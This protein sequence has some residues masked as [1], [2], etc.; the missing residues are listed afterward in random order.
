MVQRV[1]GVVAFQRG[2]LAYELA[3]PQPPGW[4]PRRR[5]RGR[6]GLR[7]LL[8]PLSILLPLDLLLIALFATVAIVVAAVSVVLL[9]GY[10]VYR[11]V[12]RRAIAERREREQAAREA[13]DRRYRH[14]LSYWNQLEICHRCVGVFLPGHAWQH[15]EVTPAGGVAPPAY[16]WT[17]ARRLAGYA[18]RFHNPQSSPQPSPEP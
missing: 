17:L 18:D 16:A 4:R 10:L 6:S 1:S 7:W 8:L 14:A 3:A 13:V 11:L 9:A 15:D 2:R 12:A 5:G